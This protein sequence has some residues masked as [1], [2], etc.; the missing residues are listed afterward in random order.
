MT[1]LVGQHALVTGA[2]TG[3]GAAVARALANEGAALSLIGRRRQP[4][5]EVAGEIENALVAPGDVTKREDV[6]ACLEMARAAHGPVTILVNNAGTAHSMPFAKLDPGD[7]RE[8]MAVNCDGAFHCC[9]AVL[10]DLLGAKAGRIVTVAS[11][12][13]RKGYAYSAPYCAAKHGVI[14]L[15][16]ALAAEFAMA[17]L[18]VNAVC[19]GFTDTEIVARTAA[20]LQEKT[21]RDTA[22]IKADLAAFNPQGR[23]LDPAET[24]N[25]VVWLCL[26]ENRSITG[27]AIAVAGGEVM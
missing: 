6:G 12:A 15:T 14:G 23:L 26:P 13:G 16:R 22:E 10:P 2:G 11:T 25:T 27:Q 20:Q 4:L 5:E 1:R 24:A 19:P 21:G 9:Q 8:I 3:I 7:W 18:T 17:S